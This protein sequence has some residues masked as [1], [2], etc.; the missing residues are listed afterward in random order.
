MF[1][2]TIRGKKKMK[3]IQAVNLEPVAK[4]DA[5]QLSG[6]CFYVNRYQYFK[7]LELI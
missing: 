5:C 7:R 4:I 6:V 2:Q 1:I 3:K